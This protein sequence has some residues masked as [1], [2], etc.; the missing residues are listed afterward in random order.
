MNHSHVQYD[1]ALTERFVALLHRTI[2]LD[3]ESIGSGAIVRAVRER[4]TAWREANASEATLDDY[5]H[6][7]NAAPEQL[8][9]LIE[10]VVVPE[11]W[12]FRDAE[13]FAALVRL[14]RLRLHD[15]P[16]KRVRVLSLPCSTGEEAY[17]IAMAFCDSGIAPERFA[18]EAIDVSERALANA[19]R[20]HYGRN[21]F[22]G[23]A[24]G[25]RDRHFE[26]TN[27]GWRLNA[28][29]AE[30]VRFT[31]ANLLQLDPHAFERFD[32]VFCRNVLIYFDPATQSAALRVLDAL[33][34]DGGM[35][36]VG[37]AET[38]LMMRE[39]MRS[40][41]IPLA[42]AFQ[43]AEPEAQ[44]VAAA[45]I[46]PWIAP[47]KPL[48]AWTVPAPR[49][50]TPAPWLIKPVAVKRDD[51]AA[52]L[53]QARALADAGQLDAAEVAARAYLESHTSSA[54][55]YYLL[56]VIADARDD[57]AASRSQYKR[58]LYLDPAHREALT[59][60]AALLQI[61]GDAAGAG[62]LLARA[63]RLEAR[64]R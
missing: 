2:G 6:E 23:H 41:K 59:H 39:G 64:P 28:A 9:D 1:H 37:P 44:P 26:R 34:A 27:D 46:K 33:L 47:S 61:D 55:A 35:L 60:L 30:R 18:V 54:D 31:H 43:R 57:R 49:P 63:E 51:T 4:F 16:E 8:Q 22:R 56:G 38:G 50:V 5:W 13:A 25:F 62:L 48:P 15:H 20:A 29:I 21:A 24:I 14:A 36:F 7:V 17:S 58:A 32:F 45:P 53:T 52:T 10:A 19:R 42:F 40:A 11:T 12:F 3:A